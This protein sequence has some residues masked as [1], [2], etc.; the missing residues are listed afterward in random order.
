MDLVD[1]L[2]VPKE[3]VM[4][5]IQGLGVMS[6]FEPAKKVVDT[7]PDSLLF[8]VDKTSKYG[9]VFLL[10]YTEA[11]VEDF[12]KGI[13]EAQEAI[14]AQK[15]AEEEAEAARVAAEWA[16]ANVVYE[17]KPVEAKPWLSETSN[18]TISEIENLKGTSYREPISLEIVR[19]KSS[20]KQKFRIL[21][22]SS[23]VGGL[24]EFRC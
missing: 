11:S 9:E 1:H 2:F 23:D 20:T 13:R 18:D 19:T 14:E 16:R 22:R 12:M 5:E 24:C 4:K 17:D 8:V 10:C 6:D 21:D 3:D 7:A 15:R